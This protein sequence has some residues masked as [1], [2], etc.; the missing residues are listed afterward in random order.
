M[1]TGNSV[2]AAVS[3]ATVYFWGAQAASLQVSAACRDRAIPMS[4]QNYV[5]KDVVGRAAGNYRLAACAPQIAA[6]PRLLYSN[7]NPAIYPFALT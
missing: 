5:C 1:V 7:V 2:E 6:A 4:P 3:A